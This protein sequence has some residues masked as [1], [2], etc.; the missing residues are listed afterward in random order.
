MPNM[1]TMPFMQAI[2]CQMCKQCQLCIIHNAN[3]AHNAICEH[4]AI[5][6]G[7]PMPI[8]HPIPNVQHIWHW[9]LHIRHWIAAY[10]ALTDS[11]LSWHTKMLSSPKQN[12][13]FAANHSSVIFVLS[14]PDMTASQYKGK[15]LCG[16]S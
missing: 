15:Y 5:L 6:T 1:H 3:N 14:F 10:L 11:K 9:M 8:V 13:L 7:H 4:N 16:A 2:Q 12:F